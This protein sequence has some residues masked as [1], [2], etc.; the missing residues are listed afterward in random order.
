MKALGF[1]KSLEFDVFQASGRWLG[2]WKKDFNVSF[3]TSSDKYTF[4]SSLKVVA[5]KCL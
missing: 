1:E 5:S 4:T 3:K 2:Q